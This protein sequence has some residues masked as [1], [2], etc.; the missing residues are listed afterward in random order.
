[1]LV[2]S[3]STGQ[4]RYLEDASTE[5]VVPSGQPVMIGGSEERAKVKGQFPVG[6]ERVHQAIK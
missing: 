2:V 1:M 5:V 6:Y 3:C 4:R